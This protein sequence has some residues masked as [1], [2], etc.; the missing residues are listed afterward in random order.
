MLEPH[1]G[2][3]DGAFIQFQDV[4]ARLLDAPGDALAVLGP[5]V[6]SVCSTIR[7]SVPCNSSS[8][9]LRLA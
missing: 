5:M 8:F 7:S 1:E 4:A 2:R 3:I 9:V 6:S